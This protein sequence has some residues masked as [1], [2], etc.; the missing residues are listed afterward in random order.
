MTK[1]TLTNLVDLQNETTAVNAINSNNTA[2]TTAFDNTLSRNGAQPNQMQANLDM[3]SNRILNL[4]APASTNEPV[5]LQDLAN[6]SVGPVTLSN[7]PTGGTT[8]QVLTKNSSSNYDAS[9]AT[10]SGG[11]GGGGGSRIKLSAPLTVYVSTVGNDTTGDGT[12]GN[13]YRTRQKA[14]NNLAS[15]YDLAGF[16]VTIQL[17]DGI[18]TDSFQTYGNQIVGQNG[19]GGII[20]NGNSSTPSNVIIRP[21]NGLG[22]AYG[23][24]FGASYTI[25]NQAIDMINSAA[26][27]VSVGQK[28]AIVFGPQNPFPDSVSSPYGIVWMSPYGNGFNN[29]S[30]SFGGFIAFGGNMII[31]PQTYVTTGTWSNGGTTVTLASTSGVTPGKFMGIEGTGIGPASSILSPPSANYI[32]NVAGNVATLAYPAGAAG[33]NVTVQLTAGGQAFLDQGGQTSVYWNTNGDPNASVFVQMNGFPF[34]SAGF[35]FGQGNCYNNAQAITFINGGQGRGPSFGYKGV[36]VIDTDFQGTPY[37]PG[38]P[39]T[40]YSA[41]WSA[42]ATTINLGATG[43]VI[44]NTINSYGSFTSSFSAGAT[45]IPISAPLIDGGC[46]VGNILNGPGIV[47]GTRVSSVGGGNATLTHA[48]YS[49]QVSANIVATPYTNQGPLQ[50]GTWITAVNGTTVTLS[51]P[52]NSAGTGNHL[53]VQPNLILTGSQFI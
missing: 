13:P 1:Y 25:Q 38:N 27:G 16:T 9:W 28:S 41:T 21:N 32:T 49:S 11:G 50:N 36:S 53:I 39:G 35:F 15:N 46:A 30:V 10:P 43:P 48:T 23:A 14:Y 5:R 7:L 2:I 52:A 47:Q 45:V 42:G 29:V 3:N 17:A 37:I 6:A 22:Y 12:A 40:L 4:A 31:Q 51:Q 18:Y 34:Y 24:A 20:F 8:G 26:D 44:G 19:A 33:T